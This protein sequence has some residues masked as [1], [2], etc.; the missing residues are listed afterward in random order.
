[1]DESTAALLKKKPEFALLFC[2]AKDKARLLLNIDNTSL[3]AM[4]NVF[5]VYT[6]LFQDNS[7]GDENFLL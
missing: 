7:W 5:E 6:S 2:D 1:M 4:E 3:V